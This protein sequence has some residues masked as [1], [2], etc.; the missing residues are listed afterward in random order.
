MI[1]EGAS[2]TEFEFGVAACVLLEIGEDGG[3]GIGADGE[4]RLVDQ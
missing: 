1:V 3:E 2:G 4:E